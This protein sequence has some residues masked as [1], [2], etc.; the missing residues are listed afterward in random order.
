MSFKY[1]YFLSGALIALIV[2][3]FFPAIASSHEIES[4]E[5]LLTYDLPTSRVRIMPVGDPKPIFSKEFGGFRAA[6]GVDSI[7]I[8]SADEIWL[9]PVVSIPFGTWPGLAPVLGRDQSGAI[10]L[11]ALA[12]DG[13]LTVLYPFNSE[14]A[15]VTFFDSES[16]FALRNPQVF[17]AVSGEILFLVDRA[18]SEAV[19][20]ISLEKGNLRSIGVG[21]GIKN[22]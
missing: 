22:P 2:G 11:A 14:R 16:K 19:S 15:S 8:F 21:S 17:R 12:N 20:V 4:C 3:N 18:D 7:D 10:I 13:V 1:K 9:E 6:V 5:T